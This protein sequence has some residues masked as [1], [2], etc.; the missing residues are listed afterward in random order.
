VLLEHGADVHAT[1][2]DG[3]T[4]LLMTRK[5]HV[6]QVLLNYGAA[7]NAR[8]KKGKTL[9]ITAAYEQWSGMIKLLIDAGAD[10][11]LS[12]KNGWTALE[13]AEARGYHEI[14]QTLLEAG[15]TLRPVYFV[16]Q[17][18]GDAIKAND[19]NEVLEALQHGANP[20][21]PAPSAPPYH[22]I[23]IC[24]IHRGDPDIVQLLLDHGV[25][26]N[27]ELDAPSGTL[28][29][30]ALSG[31]VSDSDIVIIK[32]LLE[33]GADVNAKKANGWT[34]LMSAAAQ[35]NVEATKLLIEHGADVNAVAHDGRTP[36][37]IAA[38][39]GLVAVVQ[40]LEEA[41]ATH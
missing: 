30:A 1:D 23:P 31:E 27:A 11:M 22:T 26:V 25:D 7:V 13:I 29:Q 28:L 16:T 2:E 9:L 4:A 10:F 24:A 8:D 33:Y 14:R 12:P 34:A 21:A 15:A 39:H 38:Y 20:N 36:R 41:G 3:E 35:R 40:I 6:A 17:Q 32:L 5:P 18:L 19:R 37:K